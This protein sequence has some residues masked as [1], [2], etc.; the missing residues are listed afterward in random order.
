MELV[1]R[2]NHGLLQRAS[3]FD[4][5]SWNCSSKFA[6]PLRTPTEG[7]I[8]RDLKPSIFLSPCTTVP[9]PKVI[10]FGIAK[11][12]GGKL[13]DQTVFTALSSTPAYES[14]QAALTSVDVDTRSDIYSGNSALRAATARPPLTLG[15]AET[16]SG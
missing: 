4:R 15:T 5:Q 10:D 1:R 7:V 16:G 8:H 2:V 9:V 14:E 12:I 3:A 6:G 11:A 13:T